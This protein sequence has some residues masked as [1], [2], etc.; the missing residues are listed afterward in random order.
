MRILVNAAPVL[1]RAS[2]GQAK[3]VD[4][5][6]RV[7]GVV[8]HSVVSLPAAASVAVEFVGDEREADGILVLRRL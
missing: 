3:Q 7:A 5:S 2:E 1:A 6:G 4:A 8:V